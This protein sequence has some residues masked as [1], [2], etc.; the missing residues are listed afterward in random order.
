M[1]QSRKSDKKQE[2]S[3]EK[4]EILEV[5]VDTIAHVGCRSRM[6]I[7]ILCILDVMK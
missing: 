4:G 6:R 2:L 7:D 1:I 5:S 3:I